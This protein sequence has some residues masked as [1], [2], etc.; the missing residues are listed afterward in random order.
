M[1]LPRPACLESPSCYPPSFPPSLPPSS[2]GMGFVFKE[3]GSGQIGPI[4][5][6]RKIWE[7]HGAK[8]ECFSGLMSVR[9]EKA[10]SKQVALCFGALLR[11]AHTL[12]RMTA[13][14]HLH[15]STCSCM[16]KDRSGCSP[17]TVKPSRKSLRIICHA[18]I[19]K[20]YGP[21]LSTRLEDEVLCSCI[22]T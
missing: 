4:C 12:P 15:E 3:T 16:S 9:A 22:C 19:R 5:S 21:L 11:C 13:G 10:R 18:F 2:V 14:L 1:A 20:I 7:S 8:C 17:R 6:S